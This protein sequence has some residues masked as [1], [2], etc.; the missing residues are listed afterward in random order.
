MVLRMETQK[1]SRFGGKDGDSFSVLFLMIGLV[2]ERSSAALWQV[3]SQGRA[4]AGMMQDVLVPPSNDFPKHCVLLAE[5]LG[6]RAV[7]VP[8]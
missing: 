1:R 4:G 5:P 2:S 7:A 3:A 6:G 8:S